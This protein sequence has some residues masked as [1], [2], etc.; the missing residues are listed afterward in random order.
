MLTGSH[1][2]IINMCNNII[3][4]I[5][6]KT[7]KQWVATPYISNTARIRR[8]VI[9]SVAVVYIPNIIVIVIVI[10]VVIIVDAYR[11]IILVVPKGITRD[12]NIKCHGRDI[13]FTKSVH[14]EGGVS[15]HRC[16]GVALS[17]VSAKYYDAKITT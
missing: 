16:G 14:L 9:A 1:K 11:Y 8:V 4:E 12:A 3:H 5:I 13:V 7:T 15:I 6:F 2:V 10:L 17:I